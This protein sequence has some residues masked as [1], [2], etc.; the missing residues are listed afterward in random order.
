M[1]EIAAAVHSAGETTAFPAFSPIFHHCGILICI[2][3]FC[4]AAVYR[5]L[6]SFDPIP[7]VWYAHNN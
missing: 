3:L 2:R 6:L 5:A 1:P 7:A 4:T